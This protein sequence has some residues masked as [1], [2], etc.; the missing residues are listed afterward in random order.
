M[1]EPA[2][3]H[4]CLDC[5]NCIYEETPVIK[6]AWYKSI[7]PVYAAAKNRDVEAI[8]DEYRRR[9]SL[10]GSHTRIFRDEGIPL[11]CLAQAKVDANIH[12][13][14]QKDTNL[15]SLFKFLKKQKLGVSIFST[16]AEPH[17]LPILEK[18]GVKRCVDFVV[19]PSIEGVLEKP[20]ETG[21]EEIQ[22]RVDL[23]TDKIMMV[24]D[25]ERVDLVTAK[26]LGWR[27]CLVKWG[28]RDPPVFDPKIV[29]HFIQ[30]VYN[31]QDVIYELLSEEP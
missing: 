25:R 15:V 18:L 26:A 6:E 29:D 23:P 8:E 7:I 13:Y 28:T 2:L 16:S 11:E 30:G 31:L 12:Q 21:Y 4:V 5:D 14:L 10:E 24:G 17:V 19:T 22:R 9:H 1:T 3:L 27:T 20:S